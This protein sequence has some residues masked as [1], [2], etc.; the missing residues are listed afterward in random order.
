MSEINLVT[1]LDVIDKMLYRFFVIPITKKRLLER[2]AQFAWI[3]RKDFPD[4]G[5]GRDDAMNLTKYFM[6]K[7][8]MDDTFGPTDMPSIW[9]LQKYRSDQGMFMNFAGDSHD[10]YS[11]IMDSAL[12]LLGAAPAHKQDFLDQ[13]AW[14]HEY[15]DQAAGAEVSV[16]HRLP[17]ARRPAR[18]SSRGIAPRATRA[19]GRERASRSPK[20]APTATASIPGTRTRR[21]SRT[22]S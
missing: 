2:E 18:R 3:Y 22:R 12:G 6:V 14:L 4:W 5:R 17:R 19:R 9:N 10:A 16:P 21:R 1:K 13:V 7:Q 11:V 15:L 8:P 20:S